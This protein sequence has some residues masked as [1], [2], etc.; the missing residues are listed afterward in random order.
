MT[1][2]QKAR[3]GAWLKS[4][5]MVRPPVLLLASSP[6]TLTLLLLVAAG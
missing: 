6:H 3:P 5:C 2:A 1:Q 4:L